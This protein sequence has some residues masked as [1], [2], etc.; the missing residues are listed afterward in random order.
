MGEGCIHDQGEDSGGDP[1]AVQ[2]RERFHAGGGS[3]GARGEQMVRRCVNAWEVHAWEQTTGASHLVTYLFYSN[4]TECI[5]FRWTSLGHCKT[6]SGGV[7]ALLGIQASYLGSSLIEAEPVSRVLLCPLRRARLK[8]PKKEG[9]RRLRLCA[10]LLSFRCPSGMHGRGSRTAACR[11]AQGASA[12]PS[13]ALP[14]PKK[15]RARAKRS[16]KSV[17]RCSGEQMFC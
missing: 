10:P 12:P 9:R 16:H 5:P 2:H 4:S 13:K 14:H 11:A 17:V 15:C 3:A 7:A 1:Q 8:P 6:S